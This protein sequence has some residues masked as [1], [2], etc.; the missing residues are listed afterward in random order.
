MCQHSATRSLKW[1]GSLLAVTALAICST[2]A[3]AQPIM[4]AASGSNGVAGSLYTVNPAT[5][6]ATLVAPLLAGGLPVGLTAMAYN[7]STD[8]LYGGTT[9]GSPNFPG[10]LVTINR[11]TGAVTV[12][13]S[14]LAASPAMADLTFQPGSGTMFG[15]QAAGTHALHTVNLATGAA[16]AVGT[17]IGTGL[18]GGGGLSFNSGGTLYS[19]PAANET[20]S[21]TLRTIDPTTGVHTV[22]GPFSGVPAGFEA[23]VAMDFDGSSMYGIFSDRS[24]ATTTQLGTINLST[25]AA[26]MIGITGVTDLDAFAIVPEPTSMILAGV[27]LVGVAGYWR[28]N[29][30]K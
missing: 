18:F 14:F 17:G 24:G 20:P 16:T 2:K 9:Q 29:R 1:L 13:G 23:V 15:W 27:G 5:G 6:A 10:S 19:A 21:P 4:Y 3:V 8:T 22:V 25:A 7:S 28:R 26:T 12:I 11:T 30:K